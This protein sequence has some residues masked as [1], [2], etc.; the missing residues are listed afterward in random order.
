MDT[1]PADQSVKRWPVRAATPKAAQTGN[2]D[3]TP[4]MFS[5]FVSGNRFK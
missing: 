4:A 3:P 5:W 2:A 1:Q